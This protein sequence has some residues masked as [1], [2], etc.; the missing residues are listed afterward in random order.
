MANRLPQTHKI[1]IQSAILGGCWREKVV[2]VFRFERSKSH[3]WH[4]KMGTFGESARF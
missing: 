2:S 4:L 1:N 3:F